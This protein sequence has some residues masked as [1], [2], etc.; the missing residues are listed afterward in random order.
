[1]KPT[2][3]MFRVP[4][5]V[6]AACAS[7]LVSAAPVTY[8]I[9]PDHTYP[10]FETDHMGGLSR[11]RGK[12]NQSSGT[13]VVDREAGTG[14]LEVRIDTASIDFGHDKMNEHARSADMFDVAKHPVAVYKGTL[15][16]FENGE[17]KEVEGMLTIKGVT[18]PVV[19]QIGRFLCKKHPMHGKEVCGADASGI[20]DRAEFGVDYGKNFGFDMK[21]ELEIQV[22]AVRAS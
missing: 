12:F 8:E 10:S 17:P 11:W 6:V 13:V 4:S 18:K 7:A 16:K 9:D 22:E 21:T 20:I 15:T 5:V 14:T 1:M 3:S 19:L 2:S